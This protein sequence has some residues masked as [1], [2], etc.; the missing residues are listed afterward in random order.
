MRGSVWQSEVK[1]IAGRDLP[2]MREGFCSLPVFIVSVP[3][4]LN[5]IKKLY[6]DQLRC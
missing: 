1:V 2:G 5:C 3:K 4:V 6:V